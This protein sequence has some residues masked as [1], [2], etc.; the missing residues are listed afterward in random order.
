MT[1]STARE[2]HSVRIPSALAS[3]VGVHLVSCLVGMRAQHV[4]QAVQP[5]PRTGTMVVILAVVMPRPGLM[6]VC[7]SYGTFITASMLPEL[8]CSTSTTAS[9]RQ[10]QH[11]RGTRLSR[12]ASP[13][14]TATSQYGQVAGRTVDSPEAT[15][16]QDEEVACPAPRAE[17]VRPRR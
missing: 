1:P 7:R 14:R 3:I 4:P 16:L 17:N 6:A 15:V 5:P 13:A 12:A 8:C 9:F 10:L 2:I 11:G